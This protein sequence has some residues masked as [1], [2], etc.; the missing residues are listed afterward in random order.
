MFHRNSIRIKRKKKKVGPTHI[1]ST[2]VMGNLDCQSILIGLEVPRW[3]VKHS[4]CCA[5]EGISM[6]DYERGEDCKCI[7][8]SHRQGILIE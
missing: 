2:I 6:E 8:P 3:L 4:S 7:V 1:L 5:Y